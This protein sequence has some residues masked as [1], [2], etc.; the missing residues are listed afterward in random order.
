MGSTCGYEAGNCYLKVLAGVAVNCIYI[1][2]VINPAYKVNHNAITTYVS[3]LPFSSP[4]PKPASSN[5]IPSS[6]KTGIAR[7]QNSFQ[8]CT[9]PSPT[10]HPCVLLPSFPTGLTFS[11]KNRS[12]SGSNAPTISNICGYSV[13]KADEGGV[14]ERTWVM[15]LVH[16][17]VHVRARPI[18]VVGGAGRESNA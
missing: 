15:T 9:S 18:G 12:L 6:I 11:T 13:R 1:A 7:P 4:I 3:S 17:D 10:S 8:S 5:L 2:P 14:E 16:I